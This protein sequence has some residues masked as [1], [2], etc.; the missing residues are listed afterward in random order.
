MDSQCLSVMAMFIM[1]AEKKNPSWFDKILAVKT[2]HASRPSLLACKLFSS[3]I[4]TSDQLSF[5]CFSFQ[6]ALTS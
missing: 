5:C 6:P 3:F 1:L 4:T 2:G